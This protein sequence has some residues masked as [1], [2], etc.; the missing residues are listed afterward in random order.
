MREE[1]VR[2]GYLDQNEKNGEFEMKEEKY[3]NKNNGLLLFY[4][5]EIDVF[6][7]LQGHSIDFIKRY[8]S[9]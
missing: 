9:D 1:Y 5:I 2:E 4:L 3:Q 8:F 7:A 6:Q